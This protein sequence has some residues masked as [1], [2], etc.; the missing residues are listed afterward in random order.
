MSIC[1]P[2]SYNVNIPIN[3]KQSITVKYAGFF[4]VNLL[5]KRMFK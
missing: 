1:Y 3:R 4:K 5:F 2:C